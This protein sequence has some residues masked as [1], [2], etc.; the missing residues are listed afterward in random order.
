MCVSRKILPH[1]CNVID[2]ADIYQHTEDA[3]LRIV[4]SEKTYGEKIGLLHR[5][6]SYFF[7]EAGE[8]E[9]LH[10]TTLFSRLAYFIT[11]YGFKSTLSRALHQFR[12]D[13]EE[14]QSSGAIAPPLDLSDVYRNGV[15]KSI[16]HFGPR[17]DC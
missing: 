7:S 15:K 2:S 6:F 4:D 1:T 3:L 11:K 10:F 9:G 8:E 14:Y 13:A 12:I 5:T 17:I 16:T